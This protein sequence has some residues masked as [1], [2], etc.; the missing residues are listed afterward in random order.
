MT[1]GHP[2]VWDSNGRSGRMIRRAVVRPSLFHRLI[3]TCA[4]CV[5][6]A[7][8]AMGALAWEASRDGRAHSELTGRYEVLRLNLSAVN[9]RMLAARAEIL[10]ARAAAPPARGP[11]AQGL[12]PQF[13]SFRNYLVS[14]TPEAE[15]ASAHEVQSRLDVLLDCSLAWRLAGDPASCDGVAGRRQPA[16]LRGRGPAEAG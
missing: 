5:V 9:E 8:G 10:R 6:L 15:R 16:A 3:L 13:R 2:V 14:I 1:L 4:L 12:L 7:A 11:G